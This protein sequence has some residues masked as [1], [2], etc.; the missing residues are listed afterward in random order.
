MLLFTDQEVA[1]VIKSL[2]GFWGFG[3]W[4]RLV[5]SGRG[6]ALGF[7]PGLGPDIEGR[8][9]RWQRGAEWWLRLPMGMGMEMEF[10][11]MARHRKPG[12]V[13]RVRCEAFGPDKR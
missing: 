11:R 6:I 3:V 7:A 5:W 1:G 4:K 9:M 12:C 8:A 13:L 10:W 2:E